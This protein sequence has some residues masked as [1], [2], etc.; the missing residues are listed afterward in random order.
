MKNKYGFITRAITDS[1]KKIV[2]FISLLL[3]FNMFV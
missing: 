2:G 3:A 1:E